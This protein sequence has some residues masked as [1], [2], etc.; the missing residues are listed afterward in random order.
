MLCGAA[1]HPAQPAV[2]S[3]PP[4]P[5]LSLPRVVALPACR[6]GKKHGLDFI[7]VFDENGRINSNG[8]P[9]Y[10]GMMRFDARWAIEKALT[11]LGLFRGKADNKMRLGVCSRSGDVIE[12]L[13]K[14]QWYVRCAEMGAAAAGAVRSGEL[15]LVPGEWW[16]PSRQLRWWALLRRH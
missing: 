12:P 6:C 11:E 15:K 3:S 16:S 8:G 10:A 2:T 5:P 13:I 9:A 14:P 1:A 4:P 7:T